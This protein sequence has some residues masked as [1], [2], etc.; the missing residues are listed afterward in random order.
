MDRRKFLSGL[1]GAGMASGL[2]TSCQWFSPDSEGKS[3]M[4]THGMERRPLGRA[5]DKLSIIGFGGIIVKD[6]STQNAANYVAESVDRGVNYFDVAPAYGNAEEMLGPALRPYRDQCFLACK[7]E[8]RDAVEAQK[9]LD[10]SLRL[11]KTDHFDLYQLHAMTKME[12]VE[13]VLAP[14]GAMEVFIKAREAGKV[15]RLGFSAHSEEAALAL[16]RQF[17]FDSILFPFN[18]ITWHHNGGFGHSVYEAA[19]EKK[20]GLLALKAMAHTP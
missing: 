9:A 17:D 4:F 11:L 3:N 16:I 15:R 6:E 20:M 7:T 19:A 5:G 2:A 1:V 10:N 8:K 18:F 14:G 12:D 13:K